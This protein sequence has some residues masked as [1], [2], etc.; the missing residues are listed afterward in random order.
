MRKL[1][2]PPVFED[3]EKTQTARLLHVILW[4]LILAVTSIA[5]MGIILV[6]EYVIRGGL[7]IGSVDATSLVLL[8][9][10]R[11]G[12]TR[13]TSI[14]LVVS[15]WVIVTALALTANGVH[16]PAITGYLILVLIAGL[17]L[18]SQV[19]VGTA[20]VCSLTELGMVYA[21]VAGRLPPS[22]VQ[23]TP[24]TL[25]IVSTLFMGLLIGLQ[26]LAASTVQASLQRARHE[27]A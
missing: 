27:L 23:Q 25:W 14:L 21:E 11:R 16:A 1:L 2:T 19:G 13:L 15:L 17:L 3:E 18:G 5:T 12:Y 24:V 10:T 26:Y 4:T 7:I 22:Q 9:L 6:P 8:G 20:I